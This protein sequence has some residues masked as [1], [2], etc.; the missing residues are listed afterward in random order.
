MGFFD[1]TLYSVIFGGATLFGVLTW[2][3]TPAEAWLVSFDSWIPRKRNS[4]LYVL[5][6]QAED[7][8]D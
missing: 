1:G 7:R 4:I 8:E 5:V 3:F 6:A 2:W